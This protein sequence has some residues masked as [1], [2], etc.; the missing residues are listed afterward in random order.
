MAALTLLDAKIGCLIKLLFLFRRKLIVVGPDG[1]SAD[2]F[3]IIHKNPVRDFV[4]IHRNEFAFFQPM[5]LC[6]GIVYPAVEAV[7]AEAHVRKPEVFYLIALS[8]S[9]FYFKVLLTR[10]RMLQGRDEGADGPPR[11][12]N[13]TMHLGMI[14]RNV[15][16]F[17]LGV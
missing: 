10:R 4:G 17:G 8:K 11:L 9:L 6:R 15:E 14:M 2:Q 13:R 12:Q 5:D 16:R 3:A 1:V 7:S